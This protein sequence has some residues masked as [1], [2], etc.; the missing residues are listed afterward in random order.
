MH[1]LV[2]GGG[3]FLGRAIVEQLLARGDRVRSFSRGTY[4]DLSEMGV[5]VVRGDI[6]DARIIAQACEGIDCVF[7]T[8]A[9]AGIGGP[10]QRFYKANTVGTQNVI[11][12]CRTHGV[13]RLVYTSSPSVTFAGHDQEGVNECDA[14]IDLTWLERN[15]CHYSR[16]KALGEQAVLAANSEPLV[17]CALRPHL[18]WGPG[19]PHLVPR[20]I[21]RVRSGRLRR[22]GDG[23][24]LVDVIFVENAAAA[25]LQAVDTLTQSNSPVAGKAYFLSQGEPVN[26]WPWIDDI[27][28][29]ANL[30]AVDKSISLSVALRIGKVCEWVY[31]I[32]GTT[33]EPPMTRFLA[34]QLASSHWFDIS[35]ARRDFGY[36]PQ[37]STAEGMQRLGEWLRQQ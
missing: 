11:A 8:A 22:V 24:N 10:W 33:Q 19:D 14:L 23:T 26:C 18:I 21:E 34:W 16:S 3:G 17:T 32:I 2:T 1:T 28:A 37:V 35:A 6:Q 31:R 13:P 30:P 12:A 9:I 15:G 4:P 20:L 5:E 29:L 7:H 27:L 25:H 36:Q